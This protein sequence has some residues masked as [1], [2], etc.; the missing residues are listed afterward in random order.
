MYIYVLI[1]NLNFSKPIIMPIHLININKYFLLSKCRLFSY[2][3]QPGTT[4]AKIIKF[5]LVKQHT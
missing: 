5:P 1:Y 2:D 4:F 3:F